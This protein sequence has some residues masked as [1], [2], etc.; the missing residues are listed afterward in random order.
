MIC[1]N[2]R[3]CTEVSYWAASCRIYNETCFPCQFETCPY[4]LVYDTYCLD[5]VCGP[6]PTPPS[7]SGQLGAW[8]WLLAL[9]V[10]I[11]LIA[12]IGLLRYR[13]HR[14]ST[15]E[16]QRQQQQQE[17]QQQEQQQQEQQQVQEQGRQDEQ[18]QEDEAAVLEV[19]H[20]ES[21]QVEIDPG[22][23]LLGAALPRRRRLVWQAFG[24]FFQRGAS[25]HR[26]AFVETPE[27]GAVSSGRYLVLDEEVD[28]RD[29]S[30]RA[31]ARDY[32]QEAA[33]TG[34]LSSAL[35]EDLQRHREA[36]RVTRAKNNIRYFAVAL[37]DELTSYDA[38]ANVVFLNE[39]HISRQD[40]ARLQQS[41]AQTDMIYRANSSLFTL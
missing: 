23:P 40:V 30:A 27:S 25:Q 16:Q 2:G 11:L 18:V 32:V 8:W 9:S 39:E 24:R 37:G 21:P 15:A 41:V 26:D 17:Q 28:V 12:G 7:P 19:I 10:V 14:Q 22:T 34:T 6:I 1:P 5:P 20:L 29:H 33:A 13:R 3:N 35:V 36:M 38:E 31:E 4:S